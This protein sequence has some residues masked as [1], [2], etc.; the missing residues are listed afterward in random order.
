MWPNFFP[1]LH[2]G[3]E[4][5]AP[6]RQCVSVFALFAISACQ[7]ENSALSP[8]AA[9]V[10]RQ[11]IYRQLEILENQL[12]TVITEDQYGT[13]T[14]NPR[15]WLRGS[16]VP[17]PGGFE[18]LRV[19]RIIAIEELSEL[20]APQA[21]APDFSAFWEI[22]GAYIRAGNVSRFGHGQIGLIYSRPYPIDHLSGPHLEALHLLDTLNAGADTTDFAMLLG[23]LPELAIDIRNAQRRLGLGSVSGVALPASALTQMSSAIRNSAFASDD[24]F[25]SWIETWR[26]AETE[27]AP[28]SDWAVQLTEGLQDLILP[29]MIELSVLLDTQIEAQSA[30]IPSAQMSSGYY[31]AHIQQVTSGLADGEACYNDA[32]RLAAATQADFLQILEQNWNSHFEPDEEGITLTDEV[33]IPENPLDALLLW[34]TR[35]P[36]VPPPPLPE[37]VLDPETG[38]PLPQAAA[39][40]VLPDA[41]IA[42]QNALD[43]LSSFLAAYSVQRLP[44]YDL[45]PIV[46]PPTRR[47]VSPI[48]PDRLFT[49]PDTNQI[50]SSVPLAVSTAFLDVHPMA[51]SIMDILATYYPGHAYRALKE[52]RREDMPLLSRRIGTLAFD[53]GWPIYSLSVLSDRAAFNDAPQ[54]EAAMLYRRL[55][56]FTEAEAEA[57]FLLGALTESEAVS[58]M[59]DRLGISPADALDRLLTFQ[60]EPGLGC[61]ATE[62]FLTFA[63]M[64][65]RAHG[66]LGNRLNIR[67]FHEIL[68]APGS[69]PLQLVERDVDEWIATQVN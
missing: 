29:E 20:Q 46:P 15:N 24:A 18:N 62:G 1:K 39:E 3:R 50:R 49:P 33:A 63:N 66:V 19:R 53:L 10:Q 30:S 65:E 34:Q 8:E 45:T 36:L 52:E 54:L 22:H 23:S 51:L 27:D 32:A 64:R 26:A 55:E 37:P 57:G 35:T 16:E 17:S 5:F 58:L 28:Y 7:P 31:D 38:A 60:V 6:F 11:H 59:V 68:L 12:P 40:I 13:P 42:F 4:K 9:T 67:D 56:A 47:N 14:A 43:H 2:P 21:D 61:A 48:V 44:Q 41:F 25:A 69:R